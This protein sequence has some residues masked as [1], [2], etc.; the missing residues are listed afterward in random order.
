MGTIRAVLFL[1]I[2]CSTWLCTPVAAANP[3]AATPRHVL[4]ISSYH[5]GFPTFF[6]QINGIKSVFAAKGILLDVE[7][8][9]KKRFADAESEAN[10]LTLLSHKLSLT[11]PYDAV[12]TADD[13][14]L[15]F[16]LKHKAHLF[17]TQPAVFFGV[18]NIAKAKEQNTRPD[19]TGVIEAVSMQETITLMRELLP[20]TT[21][22][23]AL[24]DTT[25][26]SLGD[27]ATFHALAP[28]FPDLRFAEQSL[29]DH[30][31]AEF[32]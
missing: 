11:K 5:P 32:A 27:L 12:M 28:P 20:G 25:P 24:V 30:S 9:D 26:S 7:F 8:M 19:I 31:F 13:D 6:Q 10:F 29:S 2:V 3:A 17:P 14:A 1:W 21:T 4:L 22:I 16:L 15:L 23:L 18:N